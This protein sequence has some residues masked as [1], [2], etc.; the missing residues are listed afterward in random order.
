MNRKSVYLPNE[1]REKIQ[2]HALEEYP[3]ECCGM[4]FGKNAENGDAELLEYL[5]MNNSCESGKKSCYYRIDPSEL[6]FHENEYRKKGLE[7]IGF[8]HSHP[9]AGAYPSGE[10][11]KNMI[12]GQVY[13]ILE[14]RNSRCK[15]I[16]VWEKD[17][18]LEQADEL[19]MNTAGGT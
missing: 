14:I 19:R 1:I 3:F 5:S 2:V 18:R 4:L 15:D 6:F 9:D 8:V 10:D 16:R 17:I 11:E 12:P 13:M 7:P